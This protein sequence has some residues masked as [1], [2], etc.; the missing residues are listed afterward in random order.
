MHSRR[1]YVLFGLIPILSFIL[2]GARALANAPYAVTATNVTMPANRGNGTSQYT[3]SA[4]PMTGT[5]S[6]GC[7]Y[8][9]SQP[10]NE[11]PICEPGGADVP[12]V[13]PMQVVAGQT[14]TG[15][16]GFLPAG[17]PIP[18][19]LRRNSHSAG[20]LAMAGLLLLGFGLRRKV[21]VW[22]ALVLMAAG[23]L[24]V[25]AGISACGGSSFN[26]TPG[27]YQYMIT[28]NNESGGTTP[29]GQGTSTTIYVT[30][31]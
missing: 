18:A 4:I 11:A 30:V 14:V 27:T 13:A 21:R 24:A 7:A 17:S 5:L 16:F 10:E 19:S 3:V 6:V 28:A 31:P 25:V 26:G 23:S 2:F 29:L 15:T 12:I 22:L 8:V 9:G 1:S 20:G